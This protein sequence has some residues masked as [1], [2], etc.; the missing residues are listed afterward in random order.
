MSWFNI[1]SACRYTA[2]AD[3]QV[4]DHGYTKI[5][6]DP[7]EVPSDNEDAAL[8][9]RT[10]CLNTSGSTKFQKRKAKGKAS[11]RKKGIS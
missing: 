6:A 2:T 8:Q 3:R 11:R 9:H 1:L 4:V 5:A 10:V 7:N